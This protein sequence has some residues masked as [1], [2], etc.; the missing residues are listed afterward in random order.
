M[1]NVISNYET[2]FIVNPDIGD[3]AT[4]ATVEKFAELIAANGTVS[5]KA[6]WGKKRLAYPIEDYEEG[7][8]VLINFSSSPQFPAELERIFNITDTILRSIVVKK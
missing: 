1:G 4:T 5:E 3:E 2:V 8:Y 6:E 7:Y